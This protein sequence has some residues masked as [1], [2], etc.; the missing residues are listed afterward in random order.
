[1]SFDFEPSENCLDETEQEPVIAVET[2]VAWA[3]AI[4]LEK[5][6]LEEWEWETDKNGQ[7]AP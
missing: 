7:I 6:L 3:N 4:A 1:M 2:I 5:G